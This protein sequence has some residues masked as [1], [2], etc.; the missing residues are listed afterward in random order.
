MSLTSL[1]LAL[2]LLAPA[3]GIEWQP[4]YDAALAL[5]A[6]EG[7]VVFVAVNMDGER[8]N[9]VLAEKT[10]G[11]RTLVKLSES[12][13]NLVASNF[14]H[15]KA[16]KTCPRFDHVECVHHREVDALV[17]E[18]LL[19]P[20]EEGYVVA[21]QHLWLDPGGKVLLSVPYSV[22]AEE[23]E[24]CFVAALRT[25]DP[26][27]EWKLGSGARAPRRLVLGGVAP[28]GEAGEAG[29]LPPTREEA[30][31]L[32]QSLKRG[33]RGQE[34]RQM[35]R[36]LA[37]AD[38]P[39]AREYM[40]SVL[41]SSASGGGGGG[42][43]GGGGMRPQEDGPDRRLQLLSWIAVASPPS[44]W[45]VCAEVLSSGEA[46]LRAQA[47]VTLEELAAPESLKAIASTLRKEKDPRIKKNLLRALG[48]VGGDDK[49]AR[50]TLLKQAGDRRDELLRH[51]AILALGSLA[52]SEEVREFLV[53][54]VRG[55]EDDADRRAALAAV[56]LSRDATWLEWFEGQELE[57]TE[58]FEALLEDA[59]AVLGGAP[60]STIRDTVAGLGEDELPRTRLFGRSREDAED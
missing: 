16:G 24:W 40:V 38:E 2:P 1:A 33:A 26:D 20:D 42:R 6:Q 58:A 57:G 8:A 34:A 9:D 27:F 29:S 7:K 4:D 41:R 35:L 45:E 5:A 43:R 18:R 54:T 39:E 51:N 19:E 48:A 32:V 28:T 49:K 12:C 17:R 31:E 46:T 13:V 14:N 3:G 60:L 11:G 59:K 23:L 55:S 30:L 47:V 22:S 56:A 25:V 50:K 52:P 53:E 44:Y 37:Q 36:R 15:A 10:Y 21:P